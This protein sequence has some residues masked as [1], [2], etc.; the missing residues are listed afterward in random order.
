MSAPA[1]ERPTRPPVGAPPARPSGPPAGP[2]LLT[3]VPLT[4]LA[5][6]CTFFT[7]L[8]LGSLFDGLDWWLPPVAGAIALAA[9]VGAVARRLSA[10]ALVMPLVYLV[11]GWCY[12]IPVAASGTEP[13]SNISILP[14]GA[15]LSGLRDLVDSA[16][17]DI[18]TLTVPVP[19]RP[20]FLFLTVAGVFL[21][22]ALVDGIAV[23]LKRPAAAGLPLLALLAVPA[24]VVERGVGL[25]P[26]SA[27]C[28]CFIALL[29]ATGRQ[30]LFGW[31]RVPAADSGALRRS[32]NATGRRIGLLALA[33]AVLVPVAIPRYT[34]FARTHGGGAASATVIEPVVT[35]TQQLHSESE[36]RLLTVR[37]TQP[38]YLRLTSLQNFDGKTFTLGRLSADSDAKVSRGLPTVQAISPETTQAQIEV[39]SQFHQRYLPLAYQPSKVTIDGD[40]RLSPQT[41]TVFSSQT[42]TAGKEYTVTSEVAKPTVDELRARSADAASLPSAIEPNVELPDDID[43]GV[44]ALAQSLTA[45]LSTEYDKA[46]AIQDLLRSS[47]YTYDLNGAPTGDNALADF[48]LRSKTGYCEQFAGAMVVLARIAGIPAR[49]AIGFTPGRLISDDTYGVTNKDAHSWPELWFPQAGWVRFEPTPRDDQTQPP[50]YAD[51]SPASQPSSTPSAV[52]P[53]DTQP[54]AT[55]SPQPTASA[56][57]SAAPAADAGGSGGSGG[58]GTLAVVGWT[59]LGL[60]AAALLLLPAAARRQRRGRRLRAGPGAAHQRWDE[61]LDTARDL[62]LMSPSTLSPRRLVSRWSTATDG[63]RALPDV[64]SRVLQRLAA[65]EELARYA[66]PDAPASAAD[67]HTPP[68]SEAE[69]RTAFQAWIRSSGTV[70]RW[71]ALLAPRS[72]FDGMRAR[73]VEPT[74]RLV[75]T[76]A[77][78][79]TE[80]MRRR[81]GRP[82]AWV[83]GRRS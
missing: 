82:L 20:G 50:A 33:I 3:A 38:D 16:G 51:Q 75:G 29:L 17:Q 14:T 77:A 53:N 54:K 13:G 12:V 10:P 2:P 24:A 62:G 35:L 60:A 78:R 28:I 49:V 27:A 40:W 70:A 57:P 66:P 23:G 63:S 39:S 41:F 37:T 9:V 45:N 7:S 4:L 21:I 1:L 74:Q 56:A 83:A 81:L 8:C 80:A 31:A 67:R 47:E 22:A 68:V 52:A 55:D 79:L 19:E 72:L 73:L 69:L 32:A 30:E 59:V 65:D 36:V 42:D 71:S 18:R 61:A 5:A 64:T 25:L 26:F 43:P 76:P 58:G 34:G 11:A 48:L 44:R 46:L 6:L 15:T